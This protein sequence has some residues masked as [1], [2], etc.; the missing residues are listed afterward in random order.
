MTLKKSLKWVNPQDISALGLDV[1]K[2]KIDICFLSK[3]QTISYQIAN[4]SQAISCFS[5]ELKIIGLTTNVPFVLESTGNY[6]LLLAKL[7]NEDNWNVKEINPIITHQYIKHTV[8][9][10]KTDTTDAKLLAKIWLIEGENLK[11]FDR[12]LSIINMRMLISYLAHLEKTIQKTKTSFSTV[13]KW[14]ETLWLS[15]GYE[16]AKMQDVIKMLEERAEW[17][18]QEILAIPLAEE[19]QEK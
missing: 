9:W 5:K 16:L 2:A 19:E 12:N 6:H 7:L 1:A 17:I 3:N 11:S 14:L 4:N 8:R 18:K 15:M 10:T 13:K